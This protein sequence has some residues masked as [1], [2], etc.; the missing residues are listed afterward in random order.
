M[1]QLIKRRDGPYGE[2]ALR[3]RGEYFEIIANGCFL[4]QAIAGDKRGG[5]EF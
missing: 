5:H 4:K 1:A 3:R 2:V